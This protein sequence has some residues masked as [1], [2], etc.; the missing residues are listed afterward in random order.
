MWTD[1]AVRTERPYPPSSTKAK[2]NFNFSK[3]SRFSSDKG[4]FLSTVKVTRALRSTKL[5]ERAD[6]MNFNWLNSFSQSFI[7][8]DKEAV[9]S[10]P[11]GFDVKEAAR[12]DAVLWHGQAIF[13]DPRGGFSE[14]EPSAVG[15]WSVIVSH[16]SSCVYTYE[17]K[18]NGCR[19]SIAAVPDRNILIR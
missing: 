8:Q 1:A 5:A 15:V 14:L 2:S 18:R 13:T 6:A 19:D 7:T 11:K 16:L 4:L 12:I 17:R 3:S 10:L 9:I